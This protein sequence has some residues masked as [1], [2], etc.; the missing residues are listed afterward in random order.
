MTCVIEADLLSSELFVQI[1]GRKMSR[2]VNLA[3]AVCVCGAAIPCT[4]YEAL[5]LQVTKYEWVRCVD[6]KALFFTKCSLNNPINLLQQCYIILSA[7]GFVFVNI[8]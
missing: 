7:D 1:R 4:L 5:L 8:L 3:S 2:G 6:G